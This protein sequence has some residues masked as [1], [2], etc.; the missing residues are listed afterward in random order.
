MSFTVTLGLRSM[1]KSRLLLHSNRDI[2]CS[3][4]TE[5]WKNIPLNDK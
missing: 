3:T 5:R 4:V 1:L 2:C